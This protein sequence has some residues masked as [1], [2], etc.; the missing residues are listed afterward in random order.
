MKVTGIVL[1][2]I[3]NL[4]TLGLL[5]LELIASGDDRCLL[6]YVSNLM[7]PKWPSPKVTTD[8]IAETITEWN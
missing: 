8:L 1:R 7:A 3:L 5:W 6:L 2:L 4:P